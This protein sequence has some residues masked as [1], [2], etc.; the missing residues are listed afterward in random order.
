M[1]YTIL[2]IFFIISLANNVYCQA[3]TDYSK[4][5]S[6]ADSLFL[7]KNYRDAALLYTKAFKMNNDQGMVKDRYYS[8]CC[9]ALIDN[10]D[11]AFYEL[12]RIATKGKFAGYD[13]ILQDN[14][15]TKLHS[16]KRWLPLMKIIQENLNE[17]LNNTIKIDND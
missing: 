11:S 10:Y 13:Q 8:A 14:Y 12:N 15:L 16:D 1:K 17:K 6:K 2:T 9:W 5:T 7:A 4:F 3:N